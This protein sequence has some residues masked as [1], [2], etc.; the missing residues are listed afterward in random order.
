MMTA[1]RFIA[2]SLISI[3]HESAK[4]T[5]LP[6]SAQNLT[7]KLPYVRTV[8]TLRTSV[9]DCALGIVVVD[10]IWWLLR[11]VLVQGGTVYTLGQ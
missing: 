10:V 8:C 7:A 6:H 2:A 5:Q 11:L 9:V 3:K 4:V 1:S